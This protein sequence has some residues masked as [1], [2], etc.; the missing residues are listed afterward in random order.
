MGE[1]WVWQDACAMQTNMV[2]LNF[3]SIVVPM[4]ARL[5]FHLRRADH[6]SDT[7]MCL[8]WLRVPERIE[9][10]IAVLTLQSSVWRC[11]PVSGTAQP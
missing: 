8:H 1:G 7:L 9:V 3:F 11:T 10:K 5:I 2:P 6:I 4:A